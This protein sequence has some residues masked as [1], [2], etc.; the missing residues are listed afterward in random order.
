[1]LTINEYDYGGAY[2]IDAED[3]FSKEDLVEYGNDIAERMGDRYDFTF[4]LAETYIEDGELYIKLNIVDEDYFVR[5]TC[6]LDMR[7]INLPKD[8]YKYADD[9]IEQ[10]CD[11]TDEFIELYKEDYD[12]SLNET[13][14]D[15]SYHPCIEG[16]YYD[17]ELDNFTT[18]LN[19]LYTKVND[20]N[21][22]TILYNYNE[23]D[24]VIE[25]IV[26]TDI[27]SGV[28][29]E[30][31]IIDI[32]KFEA[33]ITPDEVIKLFN[34]VKESDNLTIRE[35]DDEDSE[36][37]EDENDDKLLDEAL[38][39]GDPWPHWTDAYKVFGLIQNMYKGKLDVINQKVKEFYDM[40]KG[41]KSVDIAY[42][43]WQNQE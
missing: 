29:R 7:R 2:N 38:K 19:R 35:S 43:R 27:Y 6:Y 18:K 20:N 10:L 12:D 37:N 31:A 26:F 3:F 8:L 15:G 39:L 21:D 41:I 36:D 4:E 42:Q 24:N 28:E 23:A 14:A 33:G 22:Y 32:D 16:S 34:V 40:F 11:E 17:D 5:A 30:R 13:Y 1:M 9:I 25:F